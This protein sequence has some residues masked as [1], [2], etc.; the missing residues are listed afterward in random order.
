MIVQKFIDGFAAII[1]SIANALFERDPE[2]VLQLEID[3]AVARIQEARHGL[4]RQRGL[5]ESVKRQVGTGEANI[6]RLSAQIKSYLASGNRDMAAPLAVQLAAAQKDLAENKGQ[7][8]IHE[9]SYNNFLLRVQQGNKDVLKLQE[10]ANKMVAELQMSKAEAE[11]AQVAEALSTSLNGNTNLTSNIGKI[12]HV[13]QQKID[14]NRG[15]VRVAADM[16]GTGVEEI[17]ARQAAERYEAEDL[18][19]QFESEMGLVSPES[20]KIDPVVDRAVGTVKA[21]N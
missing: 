6:A 20:T 2:A 19:K 14:H 7:Y 3:R 9:E 10:R 4:E 1:N 12:E 16:S 8:Q 11:I 17:K 15:K 21:T 18:L 5:V 13:I